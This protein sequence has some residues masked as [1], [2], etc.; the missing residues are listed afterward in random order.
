MGPHTGVYYHWNNMSHRTVRHLTT[1]T[2]TR[3]LTFE[4]CLPR[5]L[6][7]FAMTVKWNPLPASWQKDRIRMAAWRAS[8]YWVV[9]L[10]RT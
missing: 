2:P 4:D 6:L 5:R 3:P 8:L 7:T 9:T 1:A 10:E